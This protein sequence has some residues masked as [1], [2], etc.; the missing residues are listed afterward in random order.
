MERTLKNVVTIIC[1]KNYGQWLGR[2]IESAVHQS[3]PNRVFVVDDGSTDNSSEIAAGLGVNLIKLHVT[4]GPS[5][6]RNQVIKET[7]DTTDVWQ[8]LDADDEM[9]RTKIEKFMPH[10]DDSNIGVVYADFETFQE[11]DGEKV[12]LN[13]HYKQTYSRGLLMR[14][15]C[16]HS[17]AAFSKK[18]IEKAGI[19]KDQV[20][21]ETMRTAEDWDLWLRI[22]KAS[23]AYHVPECLTKVLEHPQNSTNSVTKEIW[24]QNWDKIRQRMQT[25]QY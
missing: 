14:E 16:I 19:N 17:G 21:D 7:W 2:A 22:T 8:I 13:R 9:D 23:L 5:Y 6:A 1:N 11:K 12:N 4:H 20:Y 10:F 3:Y 18:A 24:N 25:G 15:C